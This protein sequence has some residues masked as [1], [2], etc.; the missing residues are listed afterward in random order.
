MTGI[1]FSITILGAIA[2]YVL[3]TLMQKENQDEHRND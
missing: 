2:I 1:Y 3:L